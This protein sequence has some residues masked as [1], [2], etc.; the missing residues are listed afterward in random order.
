MPRRACRRAPVLW[1]GGVWRTA[2]TKPCRDR[3]LTS[4]ELDNHTKVARGE[5]GRLIRLLTEQS[6]CAT[7]GSGRENESKAS[8]CSAPRARRCTTVGAGTPRS[9][10]TQSSAGQS[11]RPARSRQ[12]GQMPWLN[13]VFVWVAMYAS[14]E[15][16]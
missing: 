1:H 3:H 6:C 9:L 15:C 2:M 4:A 13:R 5:S 16:Q 10:P 8:E 11:S 12:A 7:H 14:T